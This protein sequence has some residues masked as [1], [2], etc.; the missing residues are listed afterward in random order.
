MIIG[1]TKTEFKR[2]NNFCKFEMIV[3]TES[4]KRVN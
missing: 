3:I 4:F 2:K 1:Y